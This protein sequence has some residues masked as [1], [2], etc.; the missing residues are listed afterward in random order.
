MEITNIIEI[1]LIGD[2]IALGKVAGKKSINR[3]GRNPDV[4]T[5]A[6]E[7]VWDG[8]GSY[9]FL[10][11]AAIMEVVSDNINDTNTAG[12]GARIIKIC[13]LNSNWDEDEEN[14]VM[15]GITVVQGTKQF[16]RVNKAVVL[17]S[18]SG[19]TNIGNIIIRVTGG[20]T[21]QAMILAGNGTT[22]MAIYTVPRAKTALILGGLMALNKGSVVG[23]SDR[24]ADVALKVRAFGGSFW[25]LIILGIGFGQPGK[26]ETKIPY[27]IPEKSDI[28]VRV[29]SVSD[30][31][32]DITGGV[33]MLIVDN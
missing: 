27:A 21:T 29:L 12:T 2:D 33:E 14:F 22:L 10:A 6:A 23:S 1:D 18:G 11:A 16:L 9:V 20:G 13:G 5:A 28:K 17:T 32:T 24:E 3:F 31:D 7:D 19:E 25:N 4:D 30:N 15:N 8:G 26:I